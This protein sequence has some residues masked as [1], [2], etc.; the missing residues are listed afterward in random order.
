MNTKHY[1]LEILNLPSELS[2]ETA[3]EASVLAS[4][5]NIVE[6]GFDTK[7][8]HNNLKIVTRTYHDARHNTTYRCRFYVENGKEVIKRFDGF[9]HD[10][11]T[12][13][14]FRVKRTNEE[15]D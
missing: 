1:A 9:Y 15:E 7:R 3:W 12:R 2:L 13:I 5:G 11:E 10:K 14:M 6:I 8:L 4:H